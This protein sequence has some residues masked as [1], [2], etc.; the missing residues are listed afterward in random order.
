MARRYLSPA[1]SRRRPFLLGLTALII[2]LCLTIRSWSMRE[3]V[4]GAVVY[5]EDFPLTWKHAHMARGKGGGKCL[6]S[7]RSHGASLKDSWPDPTASNITL[8]TSLP[9]V[10]YP[11]ALASA[12]R[13]TT[14]EHHRSCAPSQ[15]PSHFLVA[16]TLLLDNPSNHTPEMEEHNS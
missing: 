7:S 2:C 10:V 6:N 14:E 3:L 9:S 8:L 13:S 1:P 16:H 11:S 4:H 12:I 5:Q 15:S